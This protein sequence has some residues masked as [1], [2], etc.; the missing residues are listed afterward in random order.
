MQQLLA[1]Q[2][3]EHLNQDGVVIY[4]T[5]PAPEWCMYVCICMYVL[6]VCVCTYV[7]VCVCV[8]AYV[9]VCVCVR[10]YV[11]V[12][13]CV[14]VRMYVCVYVCVLCAHACVCVC[15]HTYIR[16]YV[17]ILCMYVCVYVCTSSTQSSDFCMHIEAF[18]K[19]VPVPCILLQGIV[20]SE[21]NRVVEAKKLAVTS[22][23]LVLVFF[24]TYPFVVLT[25]GVS[26]SFIPRG[27]PYY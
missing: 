9:C 14:Y 17:F 4:I 27:R 3:A 6:Y 23:I 7:C 12:C 24:C 11:C 8:R 2:A 26:T 13:V 10:A 5:F 15:V 18:T 16:M 22:F 20:K 1:V 19:L 25:I 21:S